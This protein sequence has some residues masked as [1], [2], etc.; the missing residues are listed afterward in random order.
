MKIFI[1]A[2]IEGITGVTHWDETDLAHAEFQAAREQMTA[3]VAAA[4]QGALDAGASEIWV[5]DSHDSGRNLIAAQLPK[6]ARLIRGWSGHPF[7]MS[8]ELDKTF[9]AL[10]LVGYH[11]RSGSG[12]NPLAHS[13][14]GKLIYLK[15]N[16]AELSEAAIDAMTSAYV[17]VP[18]VF[19]AGDQ[20]L[21]DEM[22]AF[23]P[24]I[25][26]VAVKRGVGNSSINLHPQVAVERI[27]AGMAQALTGDARQHIVPLPEHFSVEVFYRVAYNAYHDA[28][29][30]GARQ[31]GDRLVCFEADDYFDMLRFLTFTALA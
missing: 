22:T 29:Y 27:R 21:C 18:L 3:E 25:Q 12:A 19:V 16:G 4:C 11:A 24:H 8:Q 14:S 10:A 5:K 30:P 20:G 1:S 9:A 31:T 17:G 23:N 7:M 15:I 26:T 6:E 2:D 13:F 28:F